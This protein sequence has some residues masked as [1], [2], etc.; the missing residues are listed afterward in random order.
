MK[1]LLPL[2]LGFCLGVKRAVERAK[3]SLKKDK[4]VFSLGWLIHN[5][6][7]IEELEKKGV[8]TVNSL[9]QIKEGTL[10][11]RSHG[12]PLS[13]IKEAKKRG[14]KIVDATCP[15]VRKV[16]N[17]AKKLKKDSYQVV[18]IGSPEHPEVK[19]VLSGL[20]KEGKTVASPEE[21]KK[22]GEVKKLGVVVQTTENLDNF[23]KCVK[24]LLAKAEEV[25][26]FNTICK[27]IQERQEATLRIAREAELMVVVG[28]KNS[29]NTRK[30]FELCQKEGKKTYF[31]E[32]AQE[33]K[34]KKLEGF[35][36]I[37][38]TGGTSTPLSEIEKV[39]KILEGREFKWTL[40]DQK[41]KN[42]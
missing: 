38:I 9:S 3:E 21:A 34:K 39:V 14:L 13:L 37:G 22:I 35:K 11:I 4:K 12:A 16:Q 30:L 5:P 19:G 20:G 40:Q 36:K 6:Q 31:I 32:E 28:G 2:E 23:L 42:F 24:N 7:V 26:I 10:I 18:I 17:L 15:Y 25:R 41:R 27:V 33:L 8:K 29:S 1:I